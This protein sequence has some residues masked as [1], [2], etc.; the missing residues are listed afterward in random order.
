MSASR[1]QGI[2]LKTSRG[3]SHLSL[4]TTTECQCYPILQKWKLGLRMFK[5]L[6][7]G[8]A[9]INRGA[10]IF[11]RPGLPLYHMLFPLQ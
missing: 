4:T 9:C 10:G 1:V 11:K 2:T 8:H 3:S 6:V 5:S 7:Y